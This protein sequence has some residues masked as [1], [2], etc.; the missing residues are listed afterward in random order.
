MWLHPKPKGR[1]EQAD[2]QAFREQLF[3]FIMECDERWPRERDWRIGASLGGEDFKRHAMLYRHLDGMRLWPARDEGQWERNW[4]TFPANAGF[5]N[6]E[7]MLG[8]L[9]ELVEDKI[10]HYGADSR[11]DDLTLLVIYNQACMYNS[12]ADTP[13]H[14]YEDAVAELK[15]LFDKKRGAFNR[16]LL[17]IAVNPGA[18]VLKAW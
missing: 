15:R 8:P 14:S 11:F 18:R 16:V 9:R 10:S 13:L 1:I 17:Y 6:Q 5:F 7:I 4:I 2:R 3:A 12:P